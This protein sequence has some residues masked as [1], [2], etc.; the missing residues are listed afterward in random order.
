MAGQCSASKGQMKKYEAILWSTTLGYAQWL[1]PP[2]K[3]S[4]IMKVKKK[5]IGWASILGWWDDRPMDQL[6]LFF[7][8]SCKI[9]CKNPF[10]N[11]FT[12]IRIKSFECQQLTVLFSIYQNN[13]WTIRP[14]VLYWRLLDFQMITTSIWRYLKWLMIF[15]AQLVMVE[16]F[17]SF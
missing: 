6:L 15:F 16:N 11:N 10:N 8:I 2:K 7:I 14:S 5:K 17:S 12:K 3:L 1:C 9:I 13:N 4:K